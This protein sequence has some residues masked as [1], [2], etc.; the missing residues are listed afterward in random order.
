MPRLYRA[1]ISVSLT[2]NTLR[3]AERSD[4]CLIISNKHQLATKEWRC[5]NMCQQGQ[6]N[7]GH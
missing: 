6:I 4:R 5:Y 7:E 3:T 1:Q 2:F